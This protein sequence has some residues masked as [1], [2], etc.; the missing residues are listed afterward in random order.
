MRRIA[1]WTIGLLFSAVVI[2][3]AVVE[4][5]AVTSEF[6]LQNN[7]SEPIAHASV[8]AG[9]TF[10][11]FK[12]I[13]PGGKVTQTYRAS[14]GIL[15]ARVEMSSGK[16]LDAN[17]GYITNGMAFRHDIVVSDSGMEIVESALKSGR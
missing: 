17:G 14:D 6:S 11:E 1:V 12:N 15:I 7:T 2:L 3:F 4:I 10:F 16:T 13:E 9:P 8:K 5:F